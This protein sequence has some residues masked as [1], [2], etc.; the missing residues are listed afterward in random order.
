[1]RRVLYR[2][3]EVIAT[4]TVIVTEGEKD[5][6]NLAGLGFVATC[7]CG[8][9]KK[10]RDDYS[11]T[12]RTK[13]VVIIG[14]NDTDGR[15]HVEQVIESLTGIV[16]SIKNVTLPQGTKDVSDYIAATQSGVEA[17]IATLI[18]STPVLS[19]L[20]SLTTI[21]PNGDNEGVVE[22]FPEPL[23]EVAFHGLAGDIVRRIEPYTE[24][25]RAALLIQIIAAFGSVIGRN[26]HAIAD[27]SRH[28]MNLFSVLVG[29]SSKSRKGTS[30]SHVL[31]IF[32]RAE[33]PGSKI[34]LPMACPVER[35]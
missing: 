24:A 18:D 11:E 33:N 5:A 8:G 15:E 12:L 26:A 27:G 28:E 10:W 7:N 9:A 19:S 22:D 34:A 29:E 30:W 1:M 23:S 16:R 4:Q 14:D 25:D 20:N 32:E 35:A 21:A 6:D 2:L 13:D 31:R 3:P 17:S